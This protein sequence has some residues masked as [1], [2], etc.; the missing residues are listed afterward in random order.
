MAFAGIGAAHQIALNG[1]ASTHGAIAGG[2]GL[3]LGI[4]AAA[5]ASGGHLN[6]AVTSAFVVLG[7]MGDGIIKN[8]TTGCVYITAQCLG[9]FTA[10]ALVYGIYQKGDESFL[11]G[12]HTSAE[13]QKM[14][15]LY[16][17]CAGENM[18]NTM[19]YI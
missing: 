5:K 6:P 17:T 12:E 11:K 16:A 1:G 14:V 4:F 3:G 7:K 13:M 19:V 18:I 9:M 2:L 8:V 10:A 15:C